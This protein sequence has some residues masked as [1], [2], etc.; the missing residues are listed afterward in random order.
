MT[1]FDYKYLY[2]AYADDITFFV[3]DIISMKHMVYTFDYFFF[4]YFS[5]LNPNLR[6]SEIVGIGV[7]KRVQVV[8]CGICYIDVNNDTLKILGTHFSYNKKLKQEKNFF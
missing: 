7:L 6:K 1:I 2:S 3:K 5:R 4:P 8:V